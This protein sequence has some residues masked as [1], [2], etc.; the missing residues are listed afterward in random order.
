M[1]KLRILICLYVA[2]V[3][4]LFFYS[5]TQVDLNL[6]L[7]QFSIWQVIEKF[8]QHIGYFNRPLS[9]AFYLIIIFLLFIFYGIILLLAHRRQIA[10][11]EVWF[12]IGI[13]SAILVL[14][15]NAFSYDLFNYIFDAKVVTYYNQ[16]PYTHKALDF[17]ADPMLSFMRWTHRTLPY[18]P[19][20]LALTLP[21]SY[22]GFQFFLPTIIMFKIFIV[23]SFIGTIFYIGKIIKKISPDGEIFTI[24]FLG[25]NPLV[26]IESLVSA[27]NDIVMLFFAA[28]SFY[29]LL[30]RRYLRFLLIFLLSIGIKFATIF[31]LP[32]FAVIFILQKKGKKIAWE[33]VIFAMI[34]MMIAAVVTASIR[35]N[36]Q[37]W[38]LLYLF[39]FMALIAKQPYIFIPS[40][41]MSFFSLLQYLPYLWFGNWDN[42]APSILLTINILGVTSSI[43]FIAFFIAYNSFLKNHFYNNKK[44]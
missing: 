30:E 6:T 4:A 37:P 8:F 44:K 2:T 12:L 29:Y 39:P 21:I 24:V 16:N 17:P 13:T 28:A 33:T 41:I 19:V 23:A 7:S 27:H 20:W 25:L 31:L 9:T 3:V 5:F 15:Y 26:M 10:K 35:T 36:F 34:L 11:K 38:Y 32:V 42:P 14:S 43:A 22:L 18:G 1:T 40:I